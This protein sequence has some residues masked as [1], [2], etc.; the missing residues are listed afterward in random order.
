MHMT[1]PTSKKTE[2]SPKVPR[3]LSEEECRTVS[4]GGRQQAFAFSTYSGRRKS[5]E[6][7]FDANRDG[8]FLADDLI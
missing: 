5:S 8:D 6:G 2:A 1:K 4:G 3:V 7:W